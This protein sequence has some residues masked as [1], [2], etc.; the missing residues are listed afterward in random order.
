M[1]DLVL[2]GLD[3]MASV[4]VNQSGIP[5]AISYATVLP[6]TKGEK[7]WTVNSVPDIGQLQVDFLEMI[8]SLEEE[9]TRTGGGDSLGKNERR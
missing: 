2:L 7:G 9:L 5:G 8:K 6:S 1:T 3:L 4:Q